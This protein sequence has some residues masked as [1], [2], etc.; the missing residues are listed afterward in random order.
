[1][2]ALQFATVMQK[3]EQQWQ[4]TKKNI[5]IGYHHQR[6]QMGKTVTRRPTLEH[7]RFI[8]N[9]CEPYEREPR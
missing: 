4:T 2:S 7:L 3:Q 9:P 6:Q 5:I 8:R 1:M